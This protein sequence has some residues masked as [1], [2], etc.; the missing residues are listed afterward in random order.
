MFDRYTVQNLNIVSRKNGKL[1]EM[2]A[3]RKIPMGAV[4]TYEMVWPSFAQDGEA[5]RG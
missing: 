4:Q 5:S 1:R 3:I 2:W